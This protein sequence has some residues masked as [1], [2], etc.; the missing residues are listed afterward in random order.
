M[1]APTAD[2]PVP[3]LAPGPGL[4]GF[5]MG[6]LL[7]ERSAE[8][9]LSGELRVVLGRETYT[10]QVLTI[11]SN[12]RWRNSL[13]GH[14]TR[15]LDTLDA[16][17]DDMASVFA[18]FATA[19]EQMLDALYAYDEARD[20]DGQATRHGA[21]PPRDAVEELATDQEVMLATLGVW[22]VANPFAAVALSAM[23]SAE[24][25]LLRPTAATPTAGSSTPTSGAPAS[26]AGRRVSSKP[27]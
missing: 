7:P 10:L 5:D 15:L 16:A 2:A 20:A 26:T 24:P 22:S 14:F 11:A 13:E 6:S 9:I 1:V 27:V 19:T 12:R 8:E 3:G 21:L 18:A 4:A 25:Q 17:G 23:R